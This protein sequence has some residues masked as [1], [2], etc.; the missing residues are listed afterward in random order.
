M[1]YK[2]LDRLMKA[3]LVAAGRVDRA[4]SCSVVLAAA[5][6]SVRFGAPKPFVKIRERFL[7]EYS[8][9]AFLKSGYVAEVVIAAREAD[10]PL[11]EG[12]LH[13]AYK[14]APVRLVIG[15]KTRDE[16]VMRAFL[17]LS[18]KT[19][20]VAFHDAARPLITTADAERV[21]LDAFHTGAATAGSKVVDS[22]RRANESLTLTEEVDR[23]DLYAVS[24]PQVFLKDLY[25]VSRAI[26]TKDA[27]VSTDDAAYAMHA[28]FHVRVTPVSFNPKLTYPDDLVLFETFLGTNKGETT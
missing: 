21:I 14:N 12:I 18:E 22:V 25:E 5:G 6:D 28:G 11:L 13:R 1:N 19:R 20:F 15:G 27:F 17:S 23:S 3:A 4:R 16:S 9:D 2:R 26:C 10:I 7:L 8:L 24:T